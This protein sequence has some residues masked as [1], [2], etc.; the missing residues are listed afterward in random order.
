MMTLLCVSLIVLSPLQAGGNDKK[1]S[2][3]ISSSPEDINPLEDGVTDFLDENLYSHT[4]LAAKAY[5]AEDYLKAAKHYIHI[6]KQ[7]P[8]SQ[9]VLYNLACCYAKLKKPKLAGDMLFRALKAGYDDSEHLRNDKDFDPVRGDEYFDR[10]EK[11]IH[12]IVLKFGKPLFFKAPVIL[13]GRI[14]LPDNYNPEKKY[15]LVIALHG[16]GG[17]AHGFATIH[18]YADKKNFIFAVPEAPYPMKAVGLKGLNYN[19]YYVTRDKALW[20]E[21][22]PLV[23]DYV[24]NVIEKLKKQYKIGEI[25]LLGF[26]QGVSAAFYTG[27]KK[28]ELVSGIIAFAGMMPEG[29]FISKEDLENAKGLKIFI[30]HGRN[31]KA[32]DYKVSRKLRRTLKDIGFNVE[33]YGFKGGHQVNRKAF[34]KGLEWMLNNQEK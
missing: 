10:V 17:S 18:E 14:H 16:S 12:E 21:A 25:Y 31:D 11:R 2:K 28:P 13:K 34:N 23:I 4:L 5:K 1:D 22:D 32:V 6:L 19:W 33:F 26:S 24:L 15:P 8:D 3:V 27:I 7:E 30:A 9:A 20:R 29:D